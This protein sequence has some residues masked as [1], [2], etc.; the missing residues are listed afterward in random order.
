[1]LSPITSATT[2]TLP[3]APVS[4]QRPAAPNE[5]DPNS[6]PVAAVAD[7]VQLSSAAQS[8]SGCH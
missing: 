6:Q 3:P 2:Q 7:T 8:Q 4:N 1:M 5:N